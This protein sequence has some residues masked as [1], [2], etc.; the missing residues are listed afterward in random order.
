MLI[1]AVCVLWNLLTW[2]YLFCVF[3]IL[4]VVPKHIILHVLIGMRI[5]FVPRVD[6]I[7]V[8]ALFYLFVDLSDFK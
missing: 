4:G 8:S 7:V 5:F 1:F 6:G 3:F 2:W